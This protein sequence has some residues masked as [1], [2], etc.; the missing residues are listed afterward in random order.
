[1]LR[2]KLTS[3]QNS[4]LILLWVIVT[5]H[6]PS[7]LAR[8]FLDKEARVWMQ[9]AFQAWRLM[10]VCNRLA[11]ADAEVERLHDKLGRTGHSIWNMLKDELI[12]VAVRE[13]G[14]TRPRATK[15]SVPELRERIRA[16]RKPPEPDDPLVHP[17]PDLANL[18]LD[19]LQKE[20]SRRGLE[21]EPKA[22]RG[23]MI[24][25]IADDVQ[26]RKALEAL[27]TSTSDPADPTTEWFEM[28]VDSM[29]TEIHPVAPR[30]GTTRTGSE[31]SG[32][33]PK[34]KAKAKGRGRG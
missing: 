25:L 28:D 31:S 26:H 13:L 7:M 24:V 34:A 12:E 17:P 33:A 16:S 15:M 29:E 20:C 19:K 10:T 27:N 3:T 6:L 14:V 9:C 11:A 5:Q 18:S 30:R 4:S 8:R 2:L 22:T 32:L 21:P 23:Q 1:M